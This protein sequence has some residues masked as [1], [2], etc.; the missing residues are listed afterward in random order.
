MKHVVLYCMI[1][2]TQLALSLESTINNVSWYYSKEGGVITLGCENFGGGF[3][4]DYNGYCRDDSAYC[5]RTV[6]L[7]VEG[8][9]ELPS[10]LSSLPV[11]SIDPYAFSG[12]S[13]ITR[14]VVPASI[15]LI[16]KR[17]FYKCINLQEVVF[18]G[19]APDFGEEIFFGTPKSMKILVKKGSKGW[20][21][22]NSTELPDTWCGRSISYIG[23][24]SSSDSSI[25]NE[26]TKDSSYSLTD[27]VVN[28]SI[29]NVKVDKDIAIDSFVLKD[30]KVFDCAL[31]IVNTSDKV[32]NISLPAGYVYEKFSNTKPLEIPALSTNI[33]TITRT[34][35]KTFLIAREELTVEGK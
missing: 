13:K 24:E 19:D 29:V 17:S 4:S 16:R 22:P 23:D 33:L 18:E 7:N 25:G 32:V 35:E 6:S 11:A 2:L 28:R 14:V 10:I 34:D 31:R 5:Y 30:G 21:S 3:A 20:I 12:C 27:V 1:F 8:S 26:G 9:V 15:T